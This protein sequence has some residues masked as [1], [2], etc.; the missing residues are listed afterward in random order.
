[1][2]YIDSVPWFL[3]FF[4]FSIAVSLGINQRVARALAV[5]RVIAMA[6]IVSL[7]LILSATLS[8]HTGAFELHATASRSCNFLRVG[9]AS[10]H[11][12]M[13]VS[14]N[15]TLLNVVLFVPLG[16]AIGLARRSRHNVG[17]VVVGVALPFAIEATQFL[18]P[19]LARACESADVFDNLTGLV[20]GLVAGT[21]LARVRS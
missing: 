17:L 7:G 9:L 20:L 11:E 12:L 4:L 5:S 3:P 14:V 18:A 10:P 19:S 8:P 13:A 2:N 16:L 6:A 21:L 1:V 15:D